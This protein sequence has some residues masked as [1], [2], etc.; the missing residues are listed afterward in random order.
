MMRFD[1]SPDIRFQ[2]HHIGAEKQPLVIVDNVLA[3]PQALVDAACTADFYVPQ[4]TRYPGLNARLPDDY[5]SLVVPALRGPMQAAFGLPTSV[6]LDYFGYFG[7]VTVSASEA[8]PI[9]KIPH[10][11][12]PDPGQLATVHYLSRQAYGG[13]GFFRHKTTGFEA[14][15]PVRRDRY[16]ETAQ[17]ELAAAQGEEMANYDLIAEAESVFNRLIVYRG[18]VLHSAL[19]GMTSL[20]RDPAKGRLTANGFVRPRR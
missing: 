17:A 2:L 9:Q 10:H 7:L 16:V 3:E 4:H 13:T 14:I 15:D 12:G 6:Y 1:L 11:D 8:E 18:H 20:S 19:P 5:Y